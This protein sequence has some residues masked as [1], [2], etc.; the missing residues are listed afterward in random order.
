MRVEKRHEGTDQN[1]KIQLVSTVLS[2]I[3]ETVRVRVSN[4]LGSLGERE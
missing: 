2:A 1:L 3:G 4:D